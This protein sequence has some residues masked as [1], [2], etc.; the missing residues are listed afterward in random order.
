MKNVFS[1]SGLSS[2]YLFSLLFLSQNQY[3]FIEMYGFLSSYFAK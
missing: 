1:L 3:N 2:C